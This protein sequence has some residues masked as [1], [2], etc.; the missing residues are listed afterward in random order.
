M[1]YIIRVFFYI[2]GYSFD[3]FATSVNVYLSQFTLLIFLV[4]ALSVSAAA[5][6]SVNMYLVLI[7]MQPIFNSRLTLFLVFSVRFSLP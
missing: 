3:Y 7:I 4:H 6:A 5:A 2:I 1:L